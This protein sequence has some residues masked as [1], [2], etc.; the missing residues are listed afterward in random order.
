MR[1]R[2][3]T[4]WQSLNGGRLVLLCIFAITLLFGTLLWRS[5]IVNANDETLCQN[6]AA[7]IIE[8]DATL[9]SPL[10]KRLVPNPSERR[11][12]HER[13]ARRLDRLAPICHFDRPKGLR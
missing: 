1:R 6:Q 4:R 13:N 9:E 5:F 12:L 2:I 7:F 3:S 11:Q 8:D 10:G